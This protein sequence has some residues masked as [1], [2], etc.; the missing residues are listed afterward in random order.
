MQNKE[1][2]CDFMVSQAYVGKGSDT[3]HISPN[4]SLPNSS[5]SSFVP[6]IVSCIHIV[7]PR[8]LQLPKLFPSVIYV[9]SMHEQ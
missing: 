5:N 6:S 9:S 2:V 3:F 4:A 7:V 8:Y 1:N